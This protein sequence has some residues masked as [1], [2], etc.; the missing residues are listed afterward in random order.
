[1]VEGETKRLIDREDYLARLREWH[2]KRDKPIVVLV[3]DDGFGKTTLL[4]KFAIDTF[5]NLKDAVWLDCSDRDPG[6]LSL[7]NFMAMLAARRGDENLAKDAQREASL[8]EKVN[9]LVHHLD[10]H[11]TCIFI[12]GWERLDDDFRS[13]L[14]QIANANVRLWL[15]ARRLSAEDERKLDA[16]VNA[17]VL[18]VVGLLADI[19]GRELPVDE[20]LQRTRDFFVKRGWSI[21]EV[22]KIDANLVHD[23]AQKTNGGQPFWLEILKDARTVTRLKQFLEQAALAPTVSEGLKRVFDLNDAEAKNLVLAASVFRREIAR[24]ALKFVFSGAAFESILARVVGSVFLTATEMRED[25]PE[26]YSMHQLAK[27]FC[28]KELEAKPTL[29]R[30]YHARAGKYFRDAQAANPEERFQYNLEALYHFTQAANH[31]DATRTIVELAGTLDRYGQWNYLH[32]LITEARRHESQNPLFRDLLDVWEGQIYYARYKRGKPDDDARNQNL[33]KSQEFL[34]A[35]AQSIDLEV[36]A[37][38]H[39]CLERICRDETLQFE[40]ARAHADKAL[41]LRKQQYLKGGDNADQFLTES[42]YLFADLAWI[43]HCWD[44]RVPGMAQTGLKNLRSGWQKDNT[45]AIRA[46][47]LMAEAR[48]I[49][50]RLQERMSDPAEAQAALIAARESLKTYSALRNIAGIRH[51]LHAL[52]V[53]CHHANQPD[54]LT[55]AVKELERLDENIRAEMLHELAALHT[56]KDEWHSAASLLSESLDLM[57]RLNR[58]E[59]D[60]ANEKGF[61]AL[62]NF[63]VGEYARSLALLQDAEAF[64]TR[65]ELHNLGGEAFCVEYRAK[66]AYEQGDWKRAE[67]TIQQWGK[68]KCQEAGLPKDQWTR[69]P[70][71]DASWMRWLQANVHYETG[72]IEQAKLEFEECQAEFG[73]LP[74]AQARDSGLGHA[75]VDLAR[76]KAAMGLDDAIALAEEGRANI[77]RSV[78]HSFR[79][80]VAYALRRQGETPYTLKRYP[81]AIEKFQESIEIDKKTGGRKGMADSLHQQALCHEALGNIAQGYECLKEA[82]EHFQQIGVL[83]SYRNWEADLERI[84][85]EHAETQRAA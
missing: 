46:G 61:L 26:R 23:L 72:A 28:S 37:V 42:V 24:D 22:G 70:A 17:H 4:A 31:D 8:I 51:A 3:G 52:G 32:G 13:A 77:Q 21:D 15:T 74:E 14:G 45:P 83:P 2:D 81:G 71:G 6:F 40:P 35:S 84:K 48:L 57:M 78:D 64:H 54:E 73:Q 16:N 10:Q 25:V 29:K 33:Q 20:Q 47:G 62:C 82:A 66:I 9:S 79:P 44:R 1:M 34:R 80:A 56:E 58:S 39:R 63:R 76:V 49:Q 7:E 85:A 5:P 38:A 41:K 53:A 65:A 59:Y 30:E 69:L 60:I 12:D 11:P 19:L 18:P 43:Y 50:H 36:A 67:Q 68:V 55:A 27:E 75:Q